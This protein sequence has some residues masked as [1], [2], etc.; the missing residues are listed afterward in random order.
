MFKVKELEKIGYNIVQSQGDEL[1]PSDKFSNIL[2][3]LEIIMFGD[4]TCQRS[5]SQKIVYPTSIRYGGTFLVN[6]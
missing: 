5:H 4:F 6:V 1:A 2:H 3:K